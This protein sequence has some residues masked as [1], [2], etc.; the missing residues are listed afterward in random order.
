MIGNSK[1]LLLVC[2]LSVALNMVTSAVGQAETGTISLYAPLSPRSLNIS[3]ESAAT[4]YAQFTVDRSNLTLNWFVTF[5]GLTSRPTSAAIYRTGTGMRE[6]QID[7]AKG[8]PDSPLIGS[9]TLNSD[10]AAELLSGFLYV[11]IGTQK[12]TGGELRGQ[13]RR[14]PAS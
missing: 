2:G 4:G 6:I 1:Y 9:A 8:K 10:Q 12:F 14:A 3:T 7:M 13:I 11:D 5:Q